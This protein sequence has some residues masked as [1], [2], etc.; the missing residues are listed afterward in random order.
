MRIL[1]Q[2][3]NKG[4]INVLTG[5]TIELWYDT[6]ERREVVLTHKFTQPQSFNYY[7]VVEYEADEL[8]ML[9]LD[10]AIAGVF[11]YRKELTDGAGR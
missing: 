10:S 3:W 5:D 4:R 1:A 8:Q 11:G 9:G 7:A 6:P 2:R